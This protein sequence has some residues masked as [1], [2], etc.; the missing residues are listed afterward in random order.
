[1]AWSSI[2]AGDTAAESPLN[3]TLFDKIRG[4]LDYLH[5][6]KRVVMLTKPVSLTSSWESSWT[7][8]TGQGTQPSALIITVTITCFEGSF[9]GAG[10]YADFQLYNVAQDWNPPLRIRVT[11]SDAGETAYN[12]ATLFVSCDSAGKIEW[13]GDSASGAE[14]FTISVLQIGYV[15]SE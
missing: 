13:K 2:S 1:M 6:S 5:D 15:G 12:T 8:L 9:G 7:T 11:S 10:S 14:S 4:N 3:Q